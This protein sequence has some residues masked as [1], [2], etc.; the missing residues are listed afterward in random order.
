MPVGRGKEN[1]QVSRAAFLFSAG[2]VLFIDQITKALAKAF[3]VPGSSRPVLPP[4]F[5]LTLVENQGIAFGLFQKGDK[6]L[7]WVITLSIAAL[8]VIGL[9]SKKMNSKTLW[10]LSL[11]LGGA[12]GNWIDRMRFEAVTDF[13]DFR[14]WPV[15]NMADTAISIG[16]GL[17]L[18]DLLKK[19][20]SRTS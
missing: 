13:L 16:V 11:I 6:I 18:L 2:L 9:N 15:F 4:I 14:V 20:A 7:L 3:L 10:A 12:L 5:Y 17:F 8:A 1:T 19:D